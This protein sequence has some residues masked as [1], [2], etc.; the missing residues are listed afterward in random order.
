LVAAIV[1]SPIGWALCQVGAQGEGAEVVQGKALY[2]SHK[3]AICHSIDAKGGAV[4]PALDDVGK[5]WTLEK[6]VGFLQAPSSVNADSSMPAMHGTPAEIHAVAAYMMSMG[7]T[8]RVVAP[9]PDIV[10]GQQLFASEH[11]FYCHQLGNKGGKLGPALD[12]EAE[13]RRTPDFL[14]SHFKNPSAVTPGSVMPAIVLND[15]QV[16]SLIFY[17]QSLKPGVPVPAIVLPSPGQGGTE[18][19]VVEGEALYS[20]AHCSSC[21]TIGGKGTYVGPALDYEGNSG[22]TTEWIL[23]HFQKPDET[24]PGTMMPVVQGTDRQLRSLT[25]YMLSQLAQ[26]TPSA[27]L[28]KNIYGERNCGHCHGP[29]AEGTKT[30]PA[31][32]GAKAAA[33]TDAWILEHF[34]NPSAETPNSIMPRVWA[35]PWEYQSLLDYL[36]TLRT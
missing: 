5:K 19:S 33:K 20:A 35:A 27:D 16:Q 21:H 24:A 14:A 8:P 29:N 13:R 6:L 2:A 1:L 3:C 11:C 10:M 32:T 22:R 25:M 15:N 12:Q 26:I 34:R 18:P 36:K 23:A 30:A 4:G 31:L 28:G 17:I 9:E 7:G